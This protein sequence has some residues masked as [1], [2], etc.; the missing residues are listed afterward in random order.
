MGEH[1]VK[2]DPGLIPE[3]VLIPGGEFTMG[4]DAGRA[5]ERPAHRVRLPSFRAAISPVTNADYARYVANT[6]V[7]EPP[8]L[9]DERFSD[10]AQP[11][12]GVSWSEALAYCRWL[13]GNTG[14]RFR[15]PT[16]AEREYA[17]LGG[18]ETADWP[19]E[20]VPC[21]VH[22][23]YDRI[24]QLSRPHAPAPECANGYGL[25][26]MAENVHEWCSDW[27]DATYYQVSPVESPRGPSAGRRRASRGG[28]W[29]HS[30]KFTR[31]SARSAID[32]SFHYNDYGFRVYADAF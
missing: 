23:L 11:V 3:L 14:I 25:R 29:R 13:A 18:A 20:G 17:A 2:I 5:D 7:A 8:F 22:P 1:T 21:R 6:G 15:L 28:A 16:E 10:P 32:P 31:I 4:N 9:N 27:Y 12:V 19:W 26:C 30:V 24:A